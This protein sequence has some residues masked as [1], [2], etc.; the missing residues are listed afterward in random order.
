MDI[1][2]TSTQLPQEVRQKKPISY[3]AVG[4]ICA[5]VFGSGGYL[6]GV[7][8]TSQKF[9]QTA[10]SQNNTETEKMVQNAYKSELYK[11]E[12]A[13]SYNIPSNWKK[14]VFNTSVLDSSVW[15]TSPDFASNS[16]SQLQTNGVKI[17]IK[18]VR[19][20]IA[21]AATNPNTAEYNIKAGNP[22]VQ[23][24][25]QV[26]LNG[27]PAFHFWDT[28]NPDLLSADAINNEENY[29]I[30]RKKD[31]LGIRIIYGGASSNTIDYVKNLHRSE[32]NQFIKSLKFK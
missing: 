29:Y 2:D 9:N 30:Y 15:L 25:S 31:T 16:A 23:L 12:A 20:P 32:I 8:V 17:E 10:L 3:I 26:S 24:I 4:L 21:D 5:V 22:S 19:F 28:V 6:I 11:L 14:K 27:T 1:N 13:V 7:H 18:H